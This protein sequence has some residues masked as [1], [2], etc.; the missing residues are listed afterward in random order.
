MANKS[1]IAQELKKIQEKTW[2]HKQGMV[3]QIRRSVGIVEQIS[4]IF[5]KHPELP[6][7]VRD[8]EVSG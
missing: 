3:A 1:L 6:G 4:R 8:A 2:Y 5:A 7:G